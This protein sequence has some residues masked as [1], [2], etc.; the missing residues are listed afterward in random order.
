MRLAVRRSWKH[1]GSIALALLLGASG[2]AGAQQATSVAGRV[3]ARETNEPL[4]DVR[5]IAVGTA[6]FAVTNADGRYT[7]RGLPAGNVDIRVLRV[8]Y[9]EQKKSA[10]VSATQAATVDFALERTL[11]VLQEVVTTATGTQ[12]RVELGNAVSTIDVAK[13]VEETPIKNMGDLLVA[14]APGVQVLP[15][16][17][18][19]GGSRV[20]I[21]G[22][23]SLS[24]TNDPIYVIDGI[25]MTSNGTVAGAAIGVGGTTPSRVND[26]TPEEIENI[27]IVKGPS[28]ATLYGTDASNGVIVITTKRGRAGAAR[29]NVFGEMG[30]IRDRNDYPTQYAILGHAPATPTTVRRCFRHELSTGACVQDSILA[31]N[32]FHD[33]DLTMLAPGDRGQLGAQVSGGSEAITYFVSGDVQREVGPFG[34]PDFEQRRLDSAGVKILDEWDRPNKLRQGNFRTNL[35]AAINPKLDL[36]V[37]MGY[38]KL[39]QRLPQVDNNVNSFWFNAITGPGFQGAGPG[40][41]G[42]GPTGVPL[43]GYA[44]FTPGDIFQSFTNQ[45]VQRYIGSTNA[46]FRPMSWLQ[47]RADGGVD[48]TDRG[49]FALCRFAQCAPFGTN[50]LGSA[51]DA[52]AN[53]RNLT[54]NLGATASW[55]PLS[56][57]NVK[58]TGGAQYVNFKLDLSDATGS[59]LPPGAQTPAQ[60][61][62]P[63]IQSR[64]DL[65]KTLGLFIEEQAAFRDRLFLTAAVRTDQ[66]S[67]FG[68]DFQRVYYPKGSVSWIMS[69]ETFFPRFSWLD[70]FRFRASYGA[71][72]VQPGPNDA[73][74]LFG[75]T[76]VTIAAVDAGG[77]RSSALGNT[78]LKPERA[79]EFETGFEARM[80]NSRVNLELTYYNKLTKDALI[81]QTIAPSAGSQ[82]NSVKRNLGSVKNLGYEALVNAQ[83]VNR[84]PFAWDMTFSGSFNSNKLVTLGFDALGREI[85]PII[86]TT[87]QQRP[88]YPLNSYWVRPFK[89]SDAN[90]DGIITPAEVT[91]GDTAVYAG[92]SQPR[93]ELSITNGFEML[94]HRLRIQALIDHKAGGKLLNS[95]QQFICQ[96]SSACKEISTVEDVG[97]WRQARAIANRFTPVQTQWG[98]I[99]V[100]Q[101]WRIRE[102]SATYSF[103]DA[104]A[105]KYMRVRGASFTGGVRN[106]ALFTNYTGVDPEANYSQGDTQS[107]LLTAGPPMYVTARLNLR[108]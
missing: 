8:G 98:Y 4:S 48:L 24:L 70:Q 22:T 59:T 62:I 67:A 94:N 15:G 85:P 96:Q 66:N 102:I 39:D 21:R 76:P 92:Y 30:T 69:D 18:T 80:W 23:N 97:L 50:R 95:E 11:V 10:T 6:L 49:D 2:W 36:N 9:Q 5:V 25:R 7:I 57:L 58:S 77:L 75:T 108:F 100:N 33:D 26:I 104:F 74:R 78:A 47:M 40:Y 43:K 31:L 28:A 90:K 86:G 17:M 55:Q 87:I 61:T 19:G 54:A 89:F 84:R 42:V 105:Q 63:S 82:S 81:D 73:L 106:V 34:M 41:G 83:V 3:T 27:E 1:T 56:W 52:R 12:R 53:I 51:R 101:F 16:N 99:E 35:H 103:E 37:Q 68:T 72:G 64:T 14:K 60:G 79:A 20:R 45:N 65:S 71:S 93:L 32:I 38:V 29:W 107:T 46:D 13:R 44:S 88:G 91:I